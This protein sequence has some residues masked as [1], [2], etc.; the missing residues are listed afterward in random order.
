M[1]QSKTFG[2]LLGRIF[3]VLLILGVLSAPQLLSDNPSP[4]FERIRSFL[5]NVSL[6]FWFVVI[7]VLLT[8]LWVMT[9]LKKAT[10]T[11]TEGQS[12]IETMVIVEAV[13]S[14]NGGNGLATISYTPSLKFM[15][16]L[17]WLA[18]RDQNKECI[19]I[20][21]KH[22]IKRTQLYFAPMRLIGKPISARRILLSP[23]PIENIAATAL[24][25]DKLQ[26]TLVVSIKYSVSNPAY[27]ASLSAPILEI[28]NL[29]TGVVV[30]L[31]HGHTL[32]DMVKDDGTLR[33]MLKEEIGKS[34]TIK[35]FFKIDEVLKALPTGD[36]R[37]IEIDRKK[38][39]AAERQSLIE[40]EGQNKNLTAQYDRIIKMG[41][42]QLEDEFTQRNHAREKE[43]RE[44]DSHTDITK[45][46][47]ETFGEMAESGIDPS[48]MTKEFFDCISE[49]NTTG[50]IASGSHALSK[51]EN[52]LVTVPTT[53][54]NQLDI[55]KIAL[56]NI[57]NKLGII[58]YE[59][60]ESQ[61]KLKGATI[62]M[63]D[64]EIIFQCG[65]N[66]PEEQPKAT[67]RFSNGTT[68]TMDGYWISGVSNS[69]AQAL[70]VVIHQII[71]GNQ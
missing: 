43:L 64:Y 15:Q 55:E 29:I 8:I 31:I 14:Q 67:V 3:F 35:N 59:V 10:S 11:Q 26:L 33:K 13:K 45:T 20:D 48:N 57:K 66:Y 6:P 16:I 18:V 49:R 12:P 2:K 40:Q 36:E 52:L 44:L 71:P 1:S 51:D 37:I 17:G 61:S 70:L 28:T 68:Q 24:T 38:K 5:T 50:R 4:E 58:T 21:S 54:K 23:A 39:E 46:V 25:S 65:E 53:D 19:V 9:N 42:L 41:E 34:I 56:A 60:I 7:A 69:L 22:V 27:V 30:E 62:Q 47:I 32:E 63:A